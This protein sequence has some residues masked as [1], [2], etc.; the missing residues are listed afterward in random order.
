[1]TIRHRAALALILGTLAM[2]PTAASTALVATPAYAQGVLDCKDAE[3]QIP[4]IDG[5]AACNKASQL[6]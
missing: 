1:M 2:L 5:K 6:L 4:V 3:L